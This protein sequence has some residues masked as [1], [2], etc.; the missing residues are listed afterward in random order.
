MVHNHQPSEECTNFLEIISDLHDAVRQ[1]PVKPI[2]QIYRDIQT[3]YINF[4]GLFPIFDKVRSGMYRVREEF[5]PKLPQSRD[6]V[7][8]QGDQWTKTDQG[9]LFVLYQEDGVVI[10]TTDKNLQILAKCKTVQ[11][12]GTFRV[13]PSIYTQ[14]FSIHG[15]YKGHCLPLVFALLG[16]KLQ[17]T[18]E[19]VFNVIKQQMGV[20]DVI[21]SP[22]YII[23]DFE[24][25]ILGAI[26]NSFPN[27]KHKGCLF[28][29]NQA[30]WRKVQEYGLVRSFRKSKKVKKFIKMFM[31]LP[32]VPVLLVRCTFEELCQKAVS[33]K[34]ELACFTD[35]IKRT[36]INGTFP[37]KMW[38]VYQSDIRSN[39]RV[40]GWHH[41]LNSS[42]GKVH[43]HI[44]E[45]IMHLKNQ[46]SETTVQLQRIRLGAGQPA[47]KRK[48]VELDSRI[49][50]LTARY[51]NGELSTMSFLRNI[52]HSI[53]SNF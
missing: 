29:Y 31:A 47:R 7:N 53:H 6:E 24:S 11:M 48:F 50:N 38:N 21:L 36:W 52:R 8:L 25:G 40:E 13:C 23:T 32:F 5:F 49:D 14:L 37:V 26:K 20:L 17:S 33:K 4:D 15:E 3:K 16:D 18:Y 28:H 9:E 1:N 42:V 51:E 46:Q 43:P 22:E 39:N 12:D 30:L 2:P 19:K 27:S 35:Y 45:L 44:Y 34:P 10:F 41:K